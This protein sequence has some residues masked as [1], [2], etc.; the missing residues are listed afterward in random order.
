MS[1]ASPAGFIVRNSFRHPIIR[2]TIVPGNGQ[3]T[4]NPDRIP[5]FPFFSPHQARNGRPGQVFNPSPRGRS[6]NFPF[7]RPARPPF[8]CD[9]S[10]IFTENKKKLDDIYGNYF[11]PGAPV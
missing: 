9:L 11:P 4:S 3:F 7:F 1:N 10:I 5:L 6:R 2:K 8:P